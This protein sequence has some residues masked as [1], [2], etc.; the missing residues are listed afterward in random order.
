MA[1]HSTTRDYR[2]LL[3]SAICVNLVRGMLFPIIPLYVVDTGG[4]YYAVGLVVAMPLLV[5]AIMHYGWGIISDAL[6]RRR[7]ILL[8]GGTVGA[9]LFLP[10]PFVSVPLLVVLRSVQAAFLASAVLANALVTE[11][12]PESKGVS[13]GDLNIFTAI[14]W[15][16]GGVISGFVFAHGTALFFF[17]C[18][19]MLALFAALFVFLREPPRKVGEGSAAAVALP[20]RHRRELGALFVTTILLQC[21]NY[22]VFT[23]FPIHVRKLLLDHLVPGPVAVSV[24]GVLVGVASFTGILVARPIG[25]LCDGGRE[26]WT[27]RMSLLFYSLLWLALAF[28]HHPFVVFL[29]WLQ[30]VWTTFQVASV[31]YISQKTTRANR[32]KGVGFVFLAVGVGSIIGSGAAGVL[33]SFLPLAHVFLVAAGAVACGFI[34]TLLYLRP[35]SAGR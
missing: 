7:E 8:V 11:Y 35:A 34:P 9:L 31:A 18:A 27:L 16:T 32:G 24:V 29:V 1:V 12:R 2:L 20:T 28:T 30:P 13:I 33:A 23:L 21:G 6:G 15:G 4:S 19:V 5:T 3:V 10:M 17:L 26:V 22:L 14:G 25:R